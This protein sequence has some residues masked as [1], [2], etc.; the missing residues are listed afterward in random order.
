MVLNPGRT[1]SLL[2]EL[3]L[4]THTRAHRVRTKYKLLILVIYCDK[5]NQPKTELY[6]TVTV[7]SCCQIW[8]VQNSEGAQYQGC[9]SKILAATTRLA[10]HVSESQVLVPSAGFFLNISAAGAGMTQRPASALLSARAPPS[11]SLCSL[12]FLEAAGPR[13]SGFPQGAQ[14][15]R[16]KYS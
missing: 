16:S 14:D 10:K 11:A 3:F 8:W 7:V 13:W 9:V 12:G 4:N 1:A 5:T 2:G 15:S 6:K